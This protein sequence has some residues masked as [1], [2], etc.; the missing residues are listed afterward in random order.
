[1]L[2]SQCPS[3]GH[4]FWLPR[5]Q[6]RRY[7]WGFWRINAYFCPSCGVQLRLQPWVVWVRS[8]AIFLAFVCLLMARAAPEQSGVL[9][10]LAVL[11]PI[12]VILFPKRYQLIEPRT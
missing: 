10:T 12:L 8:A 11:F 1:M 2:L 6:P 7:A 4:R 5:V 3:C 9:R